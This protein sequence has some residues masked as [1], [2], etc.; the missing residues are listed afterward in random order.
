MGVEFDKLEK[1]RKLTTD[2]DKILTFSVARGFDFFS[3]FG[4]T[5]PQLPW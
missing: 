3:S 2:F 1:T 5:F 4:V